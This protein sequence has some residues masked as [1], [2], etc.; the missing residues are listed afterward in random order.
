MLWGVNQSSKSDEIQKLR[1]ELAN[2][3]KDSGSEVLNID[4]M[5]RV[6]QEESY[7]PTKDADG[8]ITFK[9][10]GTKIVVGECADGFVYTRVYY[11]LHKEDILAGLNTTN[12]VNKA[13]VAESLSSRK[14][15]SC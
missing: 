8:E 7:F 11:D 15:K 9:I 14:S 5:Y 13:Y 1:A 3:R 12:V 6:I 4:A 2:F 10:K